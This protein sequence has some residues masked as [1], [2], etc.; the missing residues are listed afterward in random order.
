[1]N[2]TIDRQASDKCYVARLHELDPRYRFD[3][4]FLECSCHTLRSTTKNATPRIRCRYELT[5]GLYEI[6]NGSRRS[7]LAIIKNRR[8]AIETEDITAVEKACL[9]SS[10]SL[11]SVICAWME[12]GKRSSQ[13]FLVVAN[14]LTAEL[15][16]SLEAESRER[17]S[18]ATQ[19]RRRWVQKMTARDAFEGI[20]SADTRGFLRRLE[21]QGNAG[22]IAA[23]LFRAQKSSTRAKMYRGSSRDKS[24]TRKWEA[25]QKLCQLLEATLYRQDWGWKV[26]PLQDYAR[27]VLY[28][29]LPQGQVSFHSTDRAAGPDY[30]GE[31]DQEYKSEV[32]ILAYCDS[33]LDCEGERRIAG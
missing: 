2:F 18:Y 14:E 3:R 6:Q 8:I 11:A 21:K 15:I 19:A 4:K 26:D 16:A 28:V 12:S 5:D 1:M 31:W 20:D 7:Y 13:G 17:R 32:R 30:P 29:E 27:W 24:Y 25:M 23:Q 22:M 10:Y 9:K 33:L